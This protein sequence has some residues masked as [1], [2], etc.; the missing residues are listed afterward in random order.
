MP[1]QN[2]SAGNVSPP[3]TPSLTHRSASFVLVLRLLDPRFGPLDWSLDGAFV[4]ETI[5]YLAV[6]TRCPERTFGFSVW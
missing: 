2:H 5:G 1:I 3:L 6:N 4:D